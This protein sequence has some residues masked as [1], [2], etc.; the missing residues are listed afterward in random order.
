[1]SNDYMMG[2]VLIG[3]LYFVNPFINAQNLVRNYSFENF[4][5]YP[6]NTEYD[7]FPCANWFPPNEATPDYFNESS[8]DKRFKIPNNVIG[9]CPT[10]EG[11]A[12]IGIIPITIDGYMEHLSSILL[13]LYHK[14]FNTE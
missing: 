2:L 7:T 8:N 4:L 13:K 5:F 10:Y 6:D 3:L 1:M 12:Y 9:Y 11:K 14:A